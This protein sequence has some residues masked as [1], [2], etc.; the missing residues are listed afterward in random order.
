MPLEKLQN[1]EYGNFR[2]L[3]QDEHQR[4]GIAWCEL[5]DLPPLNRCPGLVKTNK[6]NYLP[7][8]T[9][10]CQEKYQQPQIHRWYH[11]YGWKWRGIK[12]SLYEDEKGKREKAGLK[13]NIQKTKI[14][15]SSPITS[16]N[17]RR[18]GG[19]SDRFYFL[20]LQNHCWQWLQVMILQDICSLE[21][22]LWQT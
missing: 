9:S 17:R 18:K 19:R 20:G 15:A 2:F 12:E 6:P 22:K 14:R 3:G 11:L 13:F 8:A 4:F 16:R 10:D 21:G 7:T 5:C 1:P